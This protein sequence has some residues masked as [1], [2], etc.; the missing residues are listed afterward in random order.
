MNIRDLKTKLQVFTRKMIGNPN[1]NQ[2]STELKWL[3]PNKNSFQLFKKQKL[4]CT[5]LYHRRLKH[6][7]DFS[8]IKCIK[9][10][11]ALKDILTEN[12][13]TTEES[14]LVGEN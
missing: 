4:P 6:F 13:L 9:L 1:L 5:T 14:C 7:N 10:I 3:K 11:P 8:K 12:Q 2:N